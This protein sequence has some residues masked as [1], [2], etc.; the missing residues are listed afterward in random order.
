M[1]E[2]L[3]RVKHKKTLDGRSAN[4]RNGNTSKTV[5]TDA[6]GTVQITVPRDRDDSCRSGHRE[7]TAAQVE[8][9]G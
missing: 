1:N 6:I 3:G 9:C 2:H 8:R 4:A 5:T 7:K